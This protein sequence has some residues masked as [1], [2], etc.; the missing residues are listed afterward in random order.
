MSASPDG[1]PETKARILDAAAEAFTQ[2][3]FADTTVDDIAASVGATKGLIYYHFRTKFDIF[4]A[5]Y[6]LGM[7]QVREQVEPYANGPGSGRQRI[8]M[9][10]VAHLV[11]LM[12]DLDYH[13]VVH[14]G[15]RNQESTALKDRQR[16]AL[17]QLNNLRR[18][19]E[20]IFRRVIGEGVADGSLR[21]VDIALAARLLLSSL[22]SVDAWYRKGEGQSDHDIRRLADAIVDLTISGMAATK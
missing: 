12:K 14:Q 11:N 10:S 9:M 19:Y 22:N 3:G 2:R 20:N 5:V 4:L 17:L 13:H 16:D 8:E 18:D 1:A 15:V 6:E 7:K 21:S